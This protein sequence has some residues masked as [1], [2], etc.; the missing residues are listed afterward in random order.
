MTGDVEEEGLDELLNHQPPGKIDVMLSPHHGSPNSN[1][2]ELARWARPDFVTVSAGKTRR[3]EALQATYGSDTK[4]FSTA[5]HGAVTFR[6]EPGGNLH[7]SHIRKPGGFLR[8][9]SP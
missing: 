2:T 4:I 3:L 9:K 5:L 7:Y 1:T 8:A 6:I